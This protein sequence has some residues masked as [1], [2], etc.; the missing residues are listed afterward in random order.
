MFFSSHCLVTRP[1]RP[2][3]R[4]PSSVSARGREREEK[5]VRAAKHGRQRQRHKDG[6][7]TN[8]Q[9][10]IKA[11]PPRSSLSSSSS[12]PSTSPAPSLYADAENPYRTDAGRKR[13]AFPRRRYQRPSIR[14]P[15]S[16]LVGPGRRPRGGYPAHPATSFQ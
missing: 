12:S 8:G 4:P 2:Q 13:Y 3:T 10:P 14:G 1:A 5:V 11:T 7:R 6:S 9:P 15:G 16:L